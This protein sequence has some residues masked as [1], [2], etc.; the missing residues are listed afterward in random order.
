MAFATKMN[1]SCAIFRK[2]KIKYTARDIF[3]GRTQ[4]IKPFLSLSQS[5]RTSVRLQK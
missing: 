2:T 5:F 3:N 1:F 4:P